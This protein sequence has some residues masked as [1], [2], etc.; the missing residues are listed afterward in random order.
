MKQT[1][2]QRIGMA[3]TIY[4]SFRKLTFHG[5]AP[6]PCANDYFTYILASF[7]H[8]HFY[9]PTTISKLLFHYRE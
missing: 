3:S 9:R 2:F 7:P 4:T 6:F 8:P 5:F 1:K